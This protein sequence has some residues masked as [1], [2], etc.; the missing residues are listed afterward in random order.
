MHLGG[1]L[2]GQQMV[3]IMQQ[4]R[5]PGHCILMSGDWEALDHPCPDHV[6]ILRKPYGRDDLLRAVNHALGQRTS[7]PLAW[8]RLPTT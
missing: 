8:T 7:H 1:R 4:R 5:H 3:D 6:S 2:S